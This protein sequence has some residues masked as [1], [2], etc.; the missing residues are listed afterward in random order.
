MDG[1]CGLVTVTG[2]E[3]KRATGRFRE[4]KSLTGKEMAYYR[5][6]AIDVVGLVVANTQLQSRRAMF[7]SYRLAMELE[8]RYGVAQLGAMERETSE[9]SGREREAAEDEMR[10]Q[11]RGEAARRG[12]IRRLAYSEWEERRAG[13]D[14]GATVG[15]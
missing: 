14:G 9:M 11:K 3:A 1:M 8:V 4:A 12:E 10:E 13:C 6:T 7:L 5:D 15:R 2:G